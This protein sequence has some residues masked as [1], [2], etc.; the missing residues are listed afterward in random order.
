VLVDRFGA[1]MHEDFYGFYRGTFFQMVLVIPKDGPRQLSNHSL[2]RSSANFVSERSRVSA[3][4]SLFPGL[5]QIL[6]D[7]R[8]LARLVMD[9]VVIA[10]C[11]SED[12]LTELLNTGTLAQ[13]R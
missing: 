11:R 7:I 9:M 12:G 13:F 1:D 10:E 8:I 4:T 5:Y 2:A 6:Y 3:L